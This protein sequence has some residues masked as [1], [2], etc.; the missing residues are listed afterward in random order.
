[1]TV[2]KVLYLDDEEN[3]LNSFKA[4]FRRLYEIYTAGNAS[5]AFDILNQTS[6]HV[7]I[8]DQRMPDMTGVEFFKKV[9]T[10]HPDPIRI[11]LTGY[12]DVE[13]LADAINEGDVYRY[14]TKPWNDL[15]LNNSIRNAYEV[16]KTRVELREKV[17]ELQKTNDELNRFIYSISHELRAP[18]A[19]ALGVISLARLENVYTPHQKGS[20]Y[21]ELIE[22][23]CNK[24]DYNITNTIQYYKNSRY[25]SISET[26]DFQ[27]LATRLIALHKLANKSGEKIKFDVSIEQNV[28]F[29]G[30]VFR[31]EVIIG[32]LISNA[33]KYQRPE[34]SNKS[35]KINAKVT[36]LDAVITVAD[37]GVGILNEHLGKIFSQFFKVRNQKGTGLG[38]FIVKE[39][40]AKINGKISVQ[41]TFG[42]GTTFTIRIPNHHHNTLQ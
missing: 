13:T 19:S 11:L 9:K 33:I 38:L 36:P 3:N 26:V 12:T 21:W 39:A 5:M 20:E 25:E 22:E 18:L 41:S 4:S 6:V 31:I 1:M 2:I 14:I 37:N 15:E 10:I 28:P 40:L 7:I 34:E 17:T 32:N 27:K 24:L 42:L 23:C 8:S 29:T 35:I 30:D 16:Y